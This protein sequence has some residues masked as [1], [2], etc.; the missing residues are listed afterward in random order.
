MLQHSTS[1]DRCRLTDSRTQVT[2]A[3]LS[4]GFYLTQAPSYTVGD[5]SISIRS[6][7]TPSTV[8]IEQT[9]KPLLGSASKSAKQRFSKQ[10]DS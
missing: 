8:R 9:G 7:I 5:S 6:A 3:L 10:T 1:F 2:P 4:T